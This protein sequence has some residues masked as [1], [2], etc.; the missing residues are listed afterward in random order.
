M[1]DECLIGHQL[2]IL[3]LLT[4]LVWLRYHKAIQRWWEE[5]NR[6]PKRSYQR[7]P[8]T[9]YD[10]VD[11]CIEHAFGPPLSYTLPIPWSQ[12]KSPRGRP[13]T[14]DSQDHA[15]VNPDCPYYLITDASIHAL[16]HN[17]NRNKV[18]T[19]GQWECAC[20][21]ESRTERVGT[22]QYRLKTHSE[23]VSLAI[24]LHMKNM[25]A[26]DISEVIGKS[27]A[28]IQRW[29]D[30]GG[31]QSE[32]LHQSLFK[33]IISHHIQLD[34]LVT[35]GASNMFGFGLLSMCKPGSGSFGS[36]ATEPKRTPIACFTDLNAAFHAWSFPSSLVMA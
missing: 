24:H 25:A 27:P 18:E 11:C 10:C 4:R 23:T 7:H 5:L 3:L 32:K 33:D 31:Q 30:R 29:L 12:V 16:R 22:V 9:P 14:Y 1:L 20:C 21:L 35:K 6:K 15:C 8:R 36:L 26:A 34:E 28:T 19:A 13:K 2:I 17:G